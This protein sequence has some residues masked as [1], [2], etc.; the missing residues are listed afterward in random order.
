M[1]IPWRSEDT[2]SPTW[3][4]LVDIFAFTMVLLIL[5]SSQSLKAKDEHIDRLRAEIESYKS[6][7][8]NTQRELDSWRETLAGMEI[9][10]EERLALE[11]RL[12]AQGMRILKELAEG[13]NIRLAAI[14]VTPE[15]NFES[16]EIRIDR[17]LG[18]D[19][20]FDRGQYDLSLEDQ[21]LLRQFAP[22]LLEVI[23]DK[24][25]VFLI[26]GRADPLPYRYT[27]QRP[28]RDNIELSALRAATVAKLMEESAEGISKWLQVVGLGETGK[29]V[30]A[31]DSERAEEIYRQ[32]RRVSFIIR[33]NK[34][35]VIE[36]FIPYR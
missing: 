10:R 31:A 23:K 29:L 13:L 16:L 30:T 3:P 5:L 35:A 32:Y 11:E 6:Q 7:L 9:S 22:G 18:R 1:R 2:E 28:P 24:P 20:S 21:F 8:A 33:V 25:V 27:P 4:G 34:E 12:Q 17:F 36:S 26:N 14:Q 19:I 15:V